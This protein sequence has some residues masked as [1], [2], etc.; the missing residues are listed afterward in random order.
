MNKYIVAFDVETTGL[1]QIDDYVIQ[2]SAIKFEKHT[3]KQIKVFDH[4]IKP[5]RAYEIK[6]GA[7]E[8]HGLTKEF[9]EENGV[10]L[11]SVAPEF[12]EMFEDADV[13][14]FNGNRFDVNMIY[15][16][17]LAIGIEFPMEGKIFYDSYGIEVRLNPRKLSNVYF[18]YTGECLEDAH[19]SLADVGATIEVFKR[20]L[21]VLNE[22]NET[23][24][25]VDQWSENQLYSPE[26]SIRNAAQ[27]NESERI[28]FNIGKYRDQEFMTVC[29]TDPGYISWFKDKVA[30]PYT[31]RKLTKY[32][33]EH[34]NE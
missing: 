27:G 11:K 2:L 24:E 28:V 4:Y 18:N 17:L 1:S 20:Q 16:D 12:V 15:K 10:P 30:S 6:P 19:N 7:F 29:K 14:T 26:G 9:I 13:L 21:E 25:D 31:W 34:R 3:Y 8:A 33:K 22:D 5:I 23:G 32:Y